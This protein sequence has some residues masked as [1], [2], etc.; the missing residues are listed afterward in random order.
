M[1][2]AGLA[3]PD[4]ALAGECRVRLRPDPTCSAHQCPASS[5]PVIMAL[6]WEVGVWPAVVR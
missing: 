1:E 2:K 6:M 5:Q 4:P 3:K